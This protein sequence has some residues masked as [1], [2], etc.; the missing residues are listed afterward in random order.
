MVSLP[1]LCNDVDVDRL[2]DKYQRVMNFGS[3]NYLGF[4]ENKGPCKEAVEAI[5]DKYGVS[6]GGSRQ[7]LG[8]LLYFVFLQ[9]F[10]ITVYPRLNAPG[11]LH[12]AKNL[13]KDFIL[14]C[15]FLLGKK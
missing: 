6:S 14:F 13:Q 1:C 3:Y 5:T 2:T 12:F 11:A 7:E 8:Q 9:F 4:A 10:L 15:Q